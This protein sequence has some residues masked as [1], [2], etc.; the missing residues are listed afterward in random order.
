MALSFCLAQ[1]FLDKPLLR[2]KTVDGSLN[3]MGRTLQPAHGAGGRLLQRKPQHHYDLDEIMDAI[4]DHIAPQ[5]IKRLG[6]FPRPT[7]CPPGSNLHQLRRA[8]PPPG[9]PDQPG[10]QPPAGGHR[11]R[12]KDRLRRRLRGTS[13]TPNTRTAASTTKLPSPPFAHCLCWQAGADPGP[14]CHPGCRGRPRR[15][16]GRRR[17]RDLSAN[18]VPDFC[19]KPDY[20]FFT[21]AKRFDESAAYPCPLILT[22]NLRA[23]ADATVVNY[24]RLSA[25]CPG[26]QQCADVAAAAAPCT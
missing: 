25:R 5:G 4:Q 8:L 2:D 14:R 12:Q 18:F 23:A 1:E 26:R 6:L 11:P 22:S 16:G 3:G 17:R 24:D 20:A 7:S 21:N 15:C 10:H 19:V 13:S 9:R